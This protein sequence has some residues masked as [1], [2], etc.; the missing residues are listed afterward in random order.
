V[1]SSWIDYL[2]MPNKDTFSTNDFRATGSSAFKALRT[3]CELIN[4][5]ISDS[6][7]QFDS[8]QYVNTFLTP[9]NLFEPEIK[10]IT[11]QFQS[12][13]INRFKLSLSMIRETTQANLL[14][15]ALLTNYQPIVDHK[16]HQVV[17]IPKEYGPCNCAASSTCIYPSAIYGHV[18]TTS[19]FDVIGFYTGCFVIESLLRSTLKCFYDQNCIDALQVSFSSSS[20]MKVNALNSSLPSNYSKNSTIKDLVDNLMIEQWNASPIYE[21]YYNQCQPARCTYTVKTRNDVIYIVTTLFGI[22]GGLTTVLK[23]IIPRLVKIIRKKRQPPPPSTGKTKSK[24]F[25]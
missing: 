14:F 13:M 10:S 9:K 6:L 2:A 3:F 18:E 16:Q 7:I 23:L 1:N 20:P 12:S 24:K 25:R 21:N 15:S 17:P 8:R 5:T 4:R 11:N 22:A 19:S